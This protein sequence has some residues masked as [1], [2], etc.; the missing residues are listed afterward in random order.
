MMQFF[1]L[2]IHVRTCQGVVADGPTT[3]VNPNPQATALSVQIAL[4][5]LGAKKRLSLINQRSRNASCSVLES[6]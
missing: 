2:R 4:V 6:G 3:D 1:M 5:G